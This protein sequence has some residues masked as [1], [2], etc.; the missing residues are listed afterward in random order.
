M[1]AT[2]CSSQARPPFPSARERREA[3]AKEGRAVAGAAEELPERF[4]KL[5][6]IHFLILL[7]REILRINK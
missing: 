4:F 5:P 6:R 3:L 2:C 7:C 1:P